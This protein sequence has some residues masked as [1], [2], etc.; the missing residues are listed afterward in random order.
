[1]WL[2][3][4]EPTLR[5][6]LAM[7]PSASTTTASASPPGGAAS[8]SAIATT[9]RR[10]GALVA[11]WPADED[12]DVP[13][14]FTFDLDATSEGLRIRSRS[15]ASVPPGDTE[16]LAARLPPGA[17]VRFAAANVDAL[18]VMGFRG[19]LKSAL[20]EGA[21]PVWL[22]S[23]ASGVAF[24]WYDGDARK[25]DATP[26]PWV[27]V[28]RWEPRV[29]RAWRARGLPEPAER[30]ATA[31]LLSFVRAGDVL[32]VS[33]D[34][35]LL[36]ASLLPR[37]APA[38]GGAVTAATHG[39]ALTK[40]LER[41][42]A[43]APKGSS[44]AEG[45]QSW[46]VIASVLSSIETSAHVEDRALVSET[47]L[48]PSARATGLERS[49]VDALLGSRRLKN[50]LRLPADVDD[51]RAE[52]PVTLVVQGSRPDE[53]RRV[54]PGSDRLTVTDAGPGLER[55]RILPAPA[56]RKGEPLTEGER[57][58]YLGEGQAPAPAIRAT[59]RDIV[60]GLTSPWDRARAIVAWVHREMTYE[61]TPTS[62]DDVTL[63]D[64]RHGDC[65]EYAQLTIAL[66]RA[67]DVPARPRNG[68]LASG[69][70]LVAHAWVEFHDGQAWHEVDPTAGRTSVDAAY[71]DASIVDILPLLMDARLTV[72]AVE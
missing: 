62:L 21:P 4:D 22:W 66:L 72:T 60:G 42:A 55:V 6:W 50:S 1:V 57:R 69:R 48:R 70:S 10:P 5:Q 44:A 13:G 51:E 36:E 47:W 35:G 56:A 26:E 49:S 54:F 18:P 63:L 30:P 28:V 64:R 20:G 38:R 67:L 37:P 71:V 9:A 52:R 24:G 7:S 11:Y 39:S 59:A 27:T 17:A 41:R 23:A 33:S 19:P 29:Q 34:R 25:A 15:T 12:N 61:V 3:S 65:T 46:T 45:L 53:I 58:L 31:E 2:F 68:L 8:A 40:L 32:V 14:G 43:R 16:A